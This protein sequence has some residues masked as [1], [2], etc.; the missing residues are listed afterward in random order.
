MFKYFIVV[1]L[2]LSSVTSSAQ[3]AYGD[4]LKVFRQQ[5]VSEL[6]DIIKD[7]TAHIDFYPADENLVVMAKVELL[8][9]QPTFKMTTS[10]GK[11][12]EAKKYAVLGFVVNGKQYQLFVYQLLALTEK[13]ASAH[14]LFLPFIDK[15]SGN[16]SYAGGRYI[17]METTDIIENKVYIDFNKAYNPYCAFVS[18]YNCPIPP[19]ENVLPVAIKAGERYRKEKFKHK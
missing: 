2:F 12:K 13:E 5:Y 8:F 11:K 15:T 18:G 4:S 10:S 7:D 9:D 1:V 17:D 3:Q 6:Y 19:R 16:G 14:H